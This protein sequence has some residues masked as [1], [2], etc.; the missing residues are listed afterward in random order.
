MLCRPAVAVIRPAAPSD[1]DQ[2]A[3]QPAVAADVG[4]E[5]GVP[6]RR[7]D[8]LGLAP[9]EQVVDERMVA[10][11]LLEPPRPGVRHLDTDP[12]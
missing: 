7:R 12:S 5:P 8:P 10:A 9:C 6:E 1:P 4:V 2:R 11:Q 3:P